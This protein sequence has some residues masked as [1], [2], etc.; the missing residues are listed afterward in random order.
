MSPRPAE[1]N[2]AMLTGR[3]STRPGRSS[4]RLLGN[5]GGYLLLEVLLA[6]VLLS[7]G[8]LLITRSFASSISALSASRAHARA[9]MVLE[10][11][12]ADVESGAIGLPAVSEAEMQGTEAGCAWRIRSARP[13]AR[14]APEVS[15]TEAEITVTWTHRGGDHEVRAS[16][17]IAP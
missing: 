3:A 13:A 4:R 14:L 9:V 5:A 6:L 16:V 8:L 17:G 10:K 12:L 15:Y 11:V 2:A 7:T 1:A